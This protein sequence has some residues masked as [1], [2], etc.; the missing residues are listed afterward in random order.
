MKTL[1]MCTYA[2]ALAT[3]L[4]GCSAP[5]PNEPISPVA[6]PAPA[7]AAFHF[8]SGDLPL[9]EFDPYTIGDNLFDPCAEISDAEFAAAGFTKDPNGQAAWF[10]A[11]L[12]GC[13]ILTEDPYVGIGLMANAANLYLI[14]RKTPRI[15]GIESSII[16]GAVAVG[17]N[18]GA[19]TCF[20]V[21]ETTRGTFAAYA[22]DLTDSSPQEANCIEA[23]RI[24]EAFYR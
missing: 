12:T 11:G 9:G 15:A 19:S 18:S 21:V 8:D 24:L 16:P 3:G 23:R 13:G 22:G 6:E 1:R 20:F 14:E 2:V 4:A 10:D 17:S 5:A 7:P